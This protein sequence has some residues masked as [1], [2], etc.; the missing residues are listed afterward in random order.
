MKKENL[1]WLTAGIVLVIIIFIARKK[2]LGPVEI[3]K[4]GDK[5]NEVYGLQAV[6]SNLT[7]VTLDNMGAYD[8]ETLI[9]VQY[10]LKD[11][12]ALKD[13]DKGYVDKKFAADL[14]LM[15]SRLRNV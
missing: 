14:Y 1:V 6:I 15:Q 7:G 11:S 9:N 5:G 10:Y 4:P 3:I 12:N 2:V 8:N 13:Y